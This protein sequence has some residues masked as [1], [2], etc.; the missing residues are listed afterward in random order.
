[1]IHVGAHII[2]SLAEE[3]VKDGLIS[4]DQL[5]VARVTRQDLGE[6]LGHILIRKGY[7]SETQLLEFL[8]KLLSVPYWPLGNQEVDAS[9][10]QRIPLHSAR[11]Y[12][13]IPLREEEGKVILAMSNPLD[14]FAIEEM[15]ALLKKDVMPVLSSSEEIDLLIT[16]HY[17]LKKQRKPQ[18]I[19]VVEIMEFAAED[20]GEKAAEKLEGAAGP[21]IVQEVNRIIAQAYQEKASDIHLEPSRED[22]R[23]RYRLDGFME[24]RERFPKEMLFPLVSRIKIMGGLDIAE[25][26]IPQDGRVRLQIGGTSLDLRVA[27]YPTL[28]GEKVVLRLL[29]KEGSKSI[30]SLGFSEKDRKTFSDL[31]AR[32]H[33]IFLVTGPTGSGKSTTLYAALGRINSPDRNVISIEDPIESEIPGVNQAQINQKAGL[34]FAS[35]LRSILRQDPDVIMLGE[36]RDAETAEIA[37]RAAITGHLVLSTLHTN[38][39][40]GAISRLVD[41]GVP[42]FLISSALI[43]VLAQRLVRKICP[44][45]RVEM[46]PDLGRLGALAA[47][48]HKCFRGKGCPSCRMSGY[49]GRVGIFELAPTGDSVRKKIADRAT[50]IEIESELRR[51]GVRSILED[52]LDK[53]N[54][55]VTTLEEVLRVSQE[56]S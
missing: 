52:G 29:S 22:V 2:D 37:V 44:Y 54:Q 43:G 35:A 6:D 50:D 27:T 30:E 21:K 17:G 28:N 25:R 51:S 3:M 47:Y 24:E 7:V 10:I 9:L 34:T 45:C 12:H 19:D 40:A 8:G 14:I 26:R 38:T 1:M 11:R 5:S 53:V 33:G 56:G 18:E 32:S 48:V 13:L 55:G 31:V 15:R 16:K 39:A 23:V 41:L 42:P 4:R 20:L 46:P 49:S 36:I